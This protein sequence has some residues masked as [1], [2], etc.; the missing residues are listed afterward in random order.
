MPVELTA[1]TTA[2]FE[3]L[4]KRKRTERDWQFD[5]RNYE[6]YGFHLAHVEV[7]LPTGKR[8]DYLGPDDGW[9]IDHADKWTEAIGQSAIYTILSGVPVG[10]ILL[11]GGIEDAVHV[12]DCAAV[13]QKFG[14]PLRIERL[15]SS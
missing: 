1:D 13:C 8:V 10:V 6:R 3:R 15:L 2:E 4:L 14:I 9:E 11:V 12:A 5:P 7:R